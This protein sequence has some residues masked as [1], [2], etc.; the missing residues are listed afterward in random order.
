[1]AKACLRC[2]NLR[3]T[4]THRF[5]K[6]RPALVL[7]A[8]LAVVASAI[9][10]PPAGYYQVWGDEFDGTSLDMSK[11]DYWLLGSRRD[12]VNVTNAVSV[13]GGYLTIT[14]YTSNN[15]HYTSMVATDGKFRPRYGYWESSL[16]WANTNGMWSAFWFQS[17]TMGTY[18]FDPVVSGSEIDDSEHRYVDG[19]T[20]NIANQVQ[21]NVHW[22]GYGS[23]AQSSG[24][25]NVGSGLA[26]GFHT[27][28]FLWTPSAYTFSIDGSTVYNGGSSPVSHSTE[29][30]ILSSEVDDTS[31]TWAGYIPPAGYGSLATSTAKL[32]VDYV[33]YYA[34]TSMI[35]WTGASSSD[36]TASANYV[37]N[38]PPVSTSAVTF[39][40]LSGNNLSPTPSSNLSIGGLAFLWM[41]NGLSLGGGNTITL[42]TGGIDMVAANHSVT[43]N[44]PLNIGAAQ[45]WSIG[46]NSPGNTLTV[47]GSV[48]GSA[49]LTKSSYGTV[50]LN[51]ANT[52][53]GTLNVDTSSTTSSD[54]VVRLASANAGTNISAIA[55]RNNNSGSST[56]QL[57]SGATSAAPITLN[58][59]NTNVVAIENLSGNNSLS[60][61][62]TINVGG[63]FYVF[64][65]DAGTL[66]LGGV[67]SS[68]ATGTRNFTFQ[69]AGNILLSGSIQNG[70]A[71]V[72]VAKTGSGTLT[73]GGA[74]IYTGT[75][76]VS[77]GTL[78]VNGSIGTGALSVYGGTL[79]GNGIIAGP[80]SILS[81]GT[82]APGNSTGL[83]TIN[84]M[85]TLSGTT[86]IELNKSVPT[87]DVVSGMSTVNYGGT[88]TVNNL[89]GTLA[90]GDSFRI[91][92]ATNYSGDFTSFNLPAL[93]T[94]L[95]WNTAALSNGVLSVALGP[96]AP[97]IGQI[98]LTG[99]S[100]LLS[101]SG[102]AANYPFT[103][104]ASPDLSVPLTNWS[105]VGTGA[106]DA[107]GNFSFSNSIDPEAAQEFY[108]ILVQ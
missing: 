89:G 63:S 48:S 49:T 37:S 72:N 66:N 34:P 58:G 47:N 33:R 1:M 100:L 21:V 94:N 70:S 20:N 90:A 107:N 68:A 87:N 15:V 83:L 103:I 38:M 35:F 27:Y 85:L 45:T 40:M 3:L 59:R 31:T 102:G 99:T 79:G 108:D 28:G 18:L 42:G 24:S 7:A 29:W 78:L 104:V 84:N 55:I 53:S 105:V 82:L 52:F 56:L 81:G 69:G 43:I 96:V 92:Y 62:L 2:Y 77:N 12:A 60:G 80:V 16:E 23:A 32:T 73:L 9:A 61:N 11:W 86:V 17:P 57:A 65:S 75:T 71:V 98:S 95:V 36:L 10:T 25:G 76:T 88:L 74:N 14:T 91:F 39:S 19:S 106:F 54:G 44:C 4:D 5:M 50:I 101:G 67:I 64:Q 22:N 26:G 13:S 8:L 51:G 30:A 6:L 93:G 41:N 46:P 97:Q